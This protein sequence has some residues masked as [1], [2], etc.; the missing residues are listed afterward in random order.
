MTD[1]PEVRC[2]NYGSLV[3]IRDMH[4]LLAGRLLMSS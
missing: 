3:S 4:L 2:L 1:D